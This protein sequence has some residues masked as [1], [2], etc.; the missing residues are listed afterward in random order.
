M[1]GN[2][3]NK[4]ICL[5]CLL[6]ANPVLAQT[7]TQPKQEYHINVTGDELDLIGEGLGTQPFNKVLPLLNKLK[8]QVADQQK[9]VP[10][11]PIN[12]QQENK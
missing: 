9:V 4:T 12:P 2:K 5:V 3:V 8:Q 11:T 7:P 1:K 10:V 6:A